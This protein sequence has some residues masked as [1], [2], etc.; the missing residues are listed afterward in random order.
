MQGSGQQW[1]VRYYEDHRGNTP[2]LEFIDGLSPTDRAKVRNVLR[3][4][5]E[6][7]LNLKMPHARRIEGDLWE[8]RPGDNR[9]LYCVYTNR[10]F[11]I[12][13]GFRKTT[14]ETPE[15]HKRIARARMLELLEE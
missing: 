10:Q 1:K 9:L 15:R 2:A 12:L 13:H 5:Q 6:F 3:L 7:G 14:Q 4:L 11:V 8:L